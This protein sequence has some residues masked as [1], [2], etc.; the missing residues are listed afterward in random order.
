MKELRQGEEI[1]TPGRGA[2]E[3]AGFQKKQQRAQQHLNKL[4]PDAGKK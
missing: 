4:Q 2:N 1:T 3:N